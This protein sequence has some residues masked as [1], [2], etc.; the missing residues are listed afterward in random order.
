[1]SDAIRAA[2]GGAAD[3]VDATDLAT[4]LMGDS[5][6]TNLFMVG[7]AWQKGLIPLGEASILKAIDLNGAAVESNK[8]AFDWGRRAALDLAAVERVATPPA[9]RESQRLSQSLDEMIQR[10]REFLT[11][12]QDPRRLSS[13]S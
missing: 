2:C 11:A 8:K 3:F 12:Y 9:A 5:I 6:A 10:R 1:M 13:S 7:Y 4:A